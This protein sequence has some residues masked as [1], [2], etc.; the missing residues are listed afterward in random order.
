M[1]SETHLAQ[2]TH[3]RS[4]HARRYKQQPKRIALRPPTDVPCKR[5][6]TDDSRNASRSGHPRTFRASAPIQMTAETHRSQATHG[7][8]VQ[9]LRY[10]SQ[11]NFIAG[12][13]DDGSLAQLA[14]LDHLHQARALDLAARRLRDRGGLHE[15]HAR[16]TM[17]L[18]AMHTLHDLA[19][20]RLAGGR[21]R[22][23]V[24]Q[25]GHD[26]EALRAG[27]LA[28]DAD[29]GGIADARHVVDDLLDVRGRDVLAA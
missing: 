25:L 23:R 2:A 3:G 29:R 26:V 24:A 9:A 6:D 18:A 19:H 4:V 8:S 7:R 14:G 27:A 21:V 17:T 20:Q 15:Q 12:S 16:R 28:V 22:A 1:T 5:S 10:K 11:P 13:A